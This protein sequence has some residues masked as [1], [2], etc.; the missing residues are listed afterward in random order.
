MTHGYNADAHLRR[1]VIEGSD[2]LRHDVFKEGD[3]ITFVGTSGGPQPMMCAIV[4]LYG[5]IVVHNRESGVPCN[6]PLVQN[7]RRRGRCARGDRREFCH[8]SRIKLLERTAETSTVKHSAGHTSTHTQ[9][10]ASSG[11]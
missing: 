7:Q 4:T 9:D 5:G 1:L 3:P 2:S 8:I 11:T 6:H 10:S